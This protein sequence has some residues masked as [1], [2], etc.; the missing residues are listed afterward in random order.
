VFELLLV[1][2]TGSRICDI[3][4]SPITYPT[5]QR[6]AN[7]AALI[8]GMVRGRYASTW[9]HSYRYLC[10]P[11]GGSGDWIRVEVPVP[12]E[13]GPT[14]RAVGHAEGHEAGGADQPAD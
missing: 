10:R 8:A 1:A 11:V 6:C 7:N 3:M 2:C 12:L 9:D 4:A 13:E 14:V 5:E